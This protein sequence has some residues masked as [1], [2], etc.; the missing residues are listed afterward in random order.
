M[1]LDVYLKTPEER[2]QYDKIER[3]LKQQRS[4]NSPWSLDFYTSRGY[5]IIDAE[6]ELLLKRQS[7]KTPTMH[8]SRVD[9]YIHKG[10]TEIEAIAEVEKYKIQIG[11]VPNRL[12]LIEKYGQT[13]GADKWNDYKQNIS[14]REEKFLDKYDNIFEGK[15]NR[16]LKKGFGDNRIFKVDYTNF[17]SYTRMCK[18]I[19]RLGL[20]I[21]SNKLDNSGEKLGREYGKNGYALDHKYSI[22]GGFYHKINPFKIA[23]FNNLQLIT[24]AENTSKGQF[25][26]IEKDELLSYPTL[27]DEECLSELTKEKIKNVF[28]CKS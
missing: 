24:S 14:G 5:T 21:Y 8:P 22:Y 15:I 18:L 6:N 12:T 26:V 13:V 28:D 3:Y 20:I 23:S 16:S 4:K 1:S 17:T 7:R 27:L 10:F 2:V 11:K 19:T 9:F 25:C